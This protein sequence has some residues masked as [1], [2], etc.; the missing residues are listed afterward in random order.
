MRSILAKPFI[1]CMAERGSSSGW[2]RGAS[3]FKLRLVTGRTRVVFGLLAVAACGRTDP[4]PF[5]HRSVD[6]GGG[7]CGDG[8]L[9][10]FEDCDDANDREDD[11]CRLTCN[12]ARCGDGVLWIGVEFCDDGN[13]T[14]NDGCRPDCAPPR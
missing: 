10:P 5:V 13:Q 12:L 7:R 4:L 6:A 8:I 2:R 11:A 1:F 14:P 3:Y 9:D